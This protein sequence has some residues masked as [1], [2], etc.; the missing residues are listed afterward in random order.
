VII[1]ILFLLPE[2]TPA[3]SKN[4]PQDTVITPTPVSEIIFQDNFDNNVNGWDV[5]KH[6]YDNYSVDINIENGKLYRI[7]QT[8]EK[9][10]GS[11]GSTAIPKVS[12]KNLCLEFEA[13]LVEATNNTAIDV[14]LRATNYYDLESRGFYYLRLFQQGNGVIRLNPPGNGDIQQIRTL[15]KN[16]SWGSEVHTIRMSLQ[17]GD[18]EIYDGE[19]LLLR[20]TFTGDELLPS[21]G[22][23][24]LGSEILAPNEKVIVEFD[25]VIVYNRCP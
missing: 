12:Q 4:L 8:T 25:N 17:N 11:F 19:T 6:F 20:T 23:I 2:I 24:R 21:I 16:I 5:E 22:E 9:S 18:F 7:V 3:L 15:G 1:G 10:N 13:K 14:V